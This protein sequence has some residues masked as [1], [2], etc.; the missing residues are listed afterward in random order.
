MMNTSDADLDEWWF[1][2]DLPLPLKQKYQGYI[3][4][5]IIM[6]E[7]CWKKMKVQGEMW[8]W[9]ISS[10]NMERKKKERKTLRPPTTSMLAD[11]KLG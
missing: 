3:L 8:E 2:D 5:K 11:K 9:Q 4:C 10:N 6:W 1:E 7:C